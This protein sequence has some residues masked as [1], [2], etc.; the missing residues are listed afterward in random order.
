[1]HTGTD[2]LFVATRDVGPVPARSVDGGS[3]RAVAATGTDGI[4]RLEAA[5]PECV[6]VGDHLPDMAVETFV[7]RV[8]Q[9]A[10]DTPVVVVG[11]TA[12]LDAGTLY[13][14][15]VTAVLDTRTD[16]GHWRRYDT[17]VNTVG[18]GI[19]QFDREGCVVA[20]NDAIEDLT[21][22]DRDEL[23]GEH[24]SKVLDDAD[25]ARG[26]T[27]IRDLLGEDPVSVA[28]MEMTVERADGT[29][30]E[31]ENRIAPL[32]V[33]GEFTGSVGVVRDI[34]DRRE[35]EAELQQERDFREQLLNT[36]PV[37]IGVIGAD[38]SIHRANDRAADILGV[39]VTELQSRGY[40]DAVWT[41]TDEDGNQIPTSAYPP[42]Q[43][44]ETGEPVY[45]WVARI[46]RPDGEFVWVRFNAAPLVDETDTVDRVVLTMEEVTEHRE[47]ERELREQAALLEGI[48]N[49]VPDVMYTFDAGG[50][51]LRWNDRFTEITGYTDEEI[52]GMGPMDFIP[53]SDRERVSAAIAS[54][55]E[56]QAV[57]HVE[58]ALVTK[59]G[60]EIPYDFS[61][62]PV[63]DE[64]GEII[65][66][67]GVGHDVT[68]RVERERQI[69]R[70]RRK[71]QDL[72]RINAVI[73]DIDQA[74]IDA[75]TR[76]EAE[77][78]V[79]DRLAAADA[80]HGAT[81]GSFDA[82]G[83]YRTHVSAGV[84]PDDVSVATADC[85]EAA[86][87]AVETGRAVVEGDGDES[88]AVRVWQAAGLAIEGL[89]AIPITYEETT[90]GVLQVFADRSSAFDERER[91]VLEELGE[92]LGHAIASIEREKRERILTTL[93][94]S[95]R[96]L[97]NAETKV[98][99]SERVVDATSDVLDG[100]VGIFLFDPKRGSLTVG[101][102]TAAF[103]D[104]LAEWPPSLDS[105]DNSVW[106]AFLDDR[107]IVVD[108]LGAAEIGIDG[109]DEG[110]ALFAP[111]G[112]H[113]VFVA[114]APDRDAFGPDIRRV[115]DLFAATA[116]ATL[117]RVEGEQELRE[118]DRTLKERNRQLTHLKRINDII[119]E[120]DQSIIRASTREE[121]EHAVCDHLTGHDGF[122][123]VW[124]GTQDWAGDAVTP[125]TWAGDDHGYL[126]AVSLSMDESN[127]L[128]AVQTLRTG[129][130]THVTDS[131]RDLRAGKWRKEALKRDYRAVVS[132]PLAY[133]DVVYGALTVYTTDP[134]ALDEMSRTVLEELG[135]TLG[136]AINAIKAR[137]DLLTDRAVELELEVEDDGVFTR[138]A[139]QAGAPLTVTELVPG[140]SGTTT[141]FFTAETSD[142]DAILEPAATLVAIDDVTLLAESDER[143]RFRAQV[144]GE[145][146]PDAIVELGAR[147]RTI[148]VDAERSRLIVGLGSESEVRPFVEKLDARFPG[149]KLLARRDNPRTELTSESL[150][151][152]LETRL[153]ERQL[154]ALKTAFMSGFFESPKEQT[155][156]E[157]AASLGITQPTFNHHLRVAQRKLF[158]ILFGDR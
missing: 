21:G 118:Q 85:T 55:I 75:T 53:E 61:G 13:D 131:A 38:G 90:Y 113:G 93:Q 156:R 151:S 30:I 112:D 23:L 26:E 65:A 97:V 10:P 29:T 3:Q 12:E 102:A 11:D 78:S 157:I 101:A 64:D 154:E 124:I 41:V 22:Y 155:G 79:C 50:N 86:R 137:E 89:V 117:D 71:L 122:E 63:V 129:E 19:Y 153:T 40:D 119:R 52:R 14:A 70:Q 60:T 6:V 132:V 138:L 130:P 110:S 111:L 123:F 135:E 67:T 74:L 17:I 128:P 108:D 2:V 95:T 91:A 32:T 48:F 72:N 73:R 15:G 100:A 77:Q 105:R 68:D 120:L 9:R 25:V 150:V 149:V 99:V 35:R 84:D 126:D 46:E 146:L 116:E 34:T 106:T 36:S 28:T 114:L 16:T 142:P 92:T 109:L 44:F 45:D 83:R 88:S 27:L 139:E 51:F 148:E 43:V 24:V 141:V 107:T 8:R 81:L 58:S 115:L 7:E 57:R 104:R 5:V 1:L 133:G 69:D 121:I 147:P 87:T 76:T 82:N 98:D 49:A 143:T 127:S 136:H 145:T 96:E 144:S 66:L 158:E 20:L 134:T 39:S 4:A 31:T 42:S 59:D 56:E 94:E 62:G 80:Y 54:V 152:E 33:D 37:G 103:T 18:D 125:R 47:R 140:A